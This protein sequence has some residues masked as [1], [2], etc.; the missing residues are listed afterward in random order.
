MPEHYSVGVNVKTGETSFTAQ[1]SQN[2]LFPNPPFT[3]PPNIDFFLD[4]NSVSVPF[5]TNVTT[6][7]FVI[8]FRVPFTGTIQWKA[9]KK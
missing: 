5:K 9:T 4:A 2:I 3:A 1:T 6:N 8:R 7:G